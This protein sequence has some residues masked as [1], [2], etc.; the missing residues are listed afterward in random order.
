M[1]ITGFQ[2]D[3]HEWV[4]TWNNHRIRHSRHGTVSG[5]PDVLYTCPELQ[6]TRDHIQTTSANDIAFCREECIFRG[7]YPCEDNDVYEMCLM[8]MRENDL[9]H[10]TDT[11]QA[12]D[13]YLELRAILKPL[14]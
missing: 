5:I 3:I 7:P 10:P 14:I 6:G 12:L 11:W 9:A 2:K 8:I 13:L 1:Y 4:Q